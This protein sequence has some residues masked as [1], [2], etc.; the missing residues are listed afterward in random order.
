M[1]LL[2]HPTKRGALCLRD[3]CNSN[4]RRILIS[5]A[6][7]AS[8]NSNNNHDGGGGGDADSSKKSTSNI[9]SKHLPNI[10][11]VGGGSL[12]LYGVSK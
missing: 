5:T 8:S 2:R 10:A 9:I 4:Y 11:A 1:N 6:R 3:V 7:A 12:A